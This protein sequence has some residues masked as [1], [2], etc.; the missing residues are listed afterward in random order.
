MDSEIICM[1]KIAEGNQEAF[2]FVYKN[3][4]SKVYTT[5]MNY[6]QNSEDAEEITQD[7]FLK[8]HK[9]ASTFKGK[10]SIN[11]W[12]YR[13]TVNTALNVIEKRK[14]FKL[15][16]FSTNINEPINFEHPGVLEENKEKAKILYLVI[17]QLPDAQK[18]SFI[19]GFIEEQ[20]RQEIANIMGV[21]VKAIESLL[22]RAKANLKEKLKKI[23]FQERK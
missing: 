8:V 9:Y 10:S 15:V 17:N 21:S 19:L 5:A 16:P 18:T 7:V 3:Y 23:Y 12:I 20:P 22:Y 13:I 4:S 11:T 6:V 14:R 1:Q 2:L